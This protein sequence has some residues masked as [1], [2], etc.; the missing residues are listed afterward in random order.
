MGSN[1]WQTDSFGLS[2]DDPLSK[3]TGL[4]PYQ[5]SEDKKGHDAQLGARFPK[6]IAR[7]VSKI[8][9]QGPYVTNSDVVRDAVYIGI[10]ILS[11][12]YEKDDEW[13]AEM[14]SRKMMTD[15]EWDTG[16]YEAEERYINNLDRL[17]KNNDS[18]H[19]AQ[20]LQERVTHLKKTN[21]TRVLAILSE[22]LKR[23]HLES[24]LGEQL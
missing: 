4:K 18:D 11:L 24:L 2:L 5:Q 9:E 8:K 13:Q 6:E 22:K 16:V 19:A 20:R 14:M 12:R 23:S 10:Q 15:V 1:T 3:L 17:C 21:S 7:R